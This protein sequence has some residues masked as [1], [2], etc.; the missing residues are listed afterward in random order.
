[1]RRIRRGIALISVLLASVLLLAVI[2]LM[3]DVA[4]VQ[5]RRTS[6]E[7]RALQARAAADAGLGWVR[8][9]IYAQKGDVSRTQSALRARANHY[10]LVID[11]D[12]TADIAVSLQPARP[13][14]IDDHLDKNLQANPYIREAPLQ[15]ISTAMIGVRGEQV[16]QRTTIALLHVFLGGSPYSEIVGVIDAGG[17]SSGTSPGDAAGQVGDSTLTDLRIHAYT[18]ASGVPKP[19]DTFVDQEWSDDGVAESGLP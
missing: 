8:A 19:A 14:L 5:L 4:T 7:L 6:E 16:A 11:S 17:P 18:V 9:E 1:M 3:V 10:R 13:R 15:L 12:T 2:A